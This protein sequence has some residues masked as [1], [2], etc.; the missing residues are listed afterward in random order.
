MIDAVGYG[1]STPT[2]YETTATRAWHSP[3]PRQ[4][5]ALRPPGRTATRT[6]PTSPRAAPTPTNSAGETRTSE[7]EPELDP[8]E[9]VEATIPEIQGNGD[10]SPLKGDPVITEGVV[11]AAYPSGGLFGFYF[12]APGSGGP[13]D[14][15]TH[16]ASDGLF[17]YYPFGAGNVTVAPGDHV[18]VTG[19]VGEYAGLTQVRI[20]DSATDV[21]VLTEPA[22]A[23]VPAT[24]AW[25]STD[26]QKESLEGML[27]TPTDAF[28]VTNTY[29]TN[30]Y[31]EVGLAQGNTPLIQP[32]E[33]ADAQSAEADAVAADNAAR[34][35][36][37][38][39]ASSTNFTA[40]SYEASAW[41]PTGPVSAQR[42]PDAAVHL[43]R[44]AG[45]GGCGRDVPRRRHL[46]RGGGPDSPTYRFQPTQTVVGP[47][48][49]EAPAT[50]EN[51]RTAAPD[52]EQLPRGR[53]RPQ[54]RLVQRPQ[55]LHHPR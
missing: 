1:T 16:T 44:P 39:D 47:A 54:G 36:T 6:P 27:Y 42:R 2:S 15:A 29:S 19:Q 10:E 25:P 28:T 17:V 35:I 32:T 31:G 41:D 34:A 13:T 7:A 4:P 55:L 43:E 30:Q 46:L 12:Q 49:A 51:D 52:E 14:F 8:P 38:D 5:A 11:T 48:N 9:P 21:E 3:T 53:G 26:A 40:N 24:A 37:L 50:F 22:A 20:A 45:P 33:V 18:R 23:P